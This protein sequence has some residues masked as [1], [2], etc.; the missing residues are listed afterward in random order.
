MGW[1]WKYDYEY[2]NIFGFVAFSRSG[3]RQ[4]SSSTGVPPASWEIVEKQDA[5]LFLLAEEGKGTGGENRTLFFELLAVERGVWRLGVGGNG[6]IGGTEGTEGTRGGSWA[7]TGNLE[8][9]GF[10]LTT[11]T[12]SVLEPT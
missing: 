9:T 2:E 10:N 1:I 11:E 5:Y 8:R 4:S 6:G 3:R 12:K 7:G